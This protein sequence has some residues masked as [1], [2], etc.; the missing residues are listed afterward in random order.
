LKYPFWVL[1][2]WS[3]FNDH[4]ILEHFAEIPKEP[5]FPA[6]IKSSSKPRRTRGCRFAFNTKSIAWCSRS[7]LIFFHHA[8]AV[9][10]AAIDKLMSVKY[11]GHT[12]IL[13]TKDFQQTWN[14]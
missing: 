9:K 4:N 14:N 2:G 12:T 13:K 8:A 1:R 5:K 7:R 3:G 6:S 10:R 11:G